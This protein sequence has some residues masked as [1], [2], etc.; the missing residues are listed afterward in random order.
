MKQ[1]ISTIFFELI[2]HTIIGEDINND[3]IA[4]I[5]PDILPALF[6]SMGTSAKAPFTCH[7]EVVVGDMEGLGG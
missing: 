1:K 3:V 2:R 6:S 5:T 4:L 7:L